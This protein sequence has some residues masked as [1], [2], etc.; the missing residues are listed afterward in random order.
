MNKS[1]FTLKPAMFGG[2]TMQHSAKIADISNDD[3]P[4]VIQKYAVQIAYEATQQEYD[5]QQLSGDR[6]R[7]QAIVRT[8]LER[9]EYIT[10]KLEAKHG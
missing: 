7:I 9:A 5:E 3:M 6:I 1:K 2:I 10:Q 8:R 4:F